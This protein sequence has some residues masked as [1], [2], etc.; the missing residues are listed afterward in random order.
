M[1]FKQYLA[2]SWEF[3]GEMP[4]FAKFLDEYMSEFGTKLKKKSEWGGLILRFYNVIKKTRDA[5]EFINNFN[6]VAEDF[7]VSV[8]LSSNPSDKDIAAAIKQVANG[9]M[10]EFAVSIIWEPCQKLIKSDKNL[11]SKMPKKSL[12][13]SW[14]FKSSMPEYAKFLDDYI[15]KFGTK[16]KKKSEWGDFIIRFFSAIK[17]D[18]SSVK[19]F[20]SNFNMVIED[21]EID[22][23]LELSSNPSDNDIAVVIKNIADSDMEEFAMCVTWEA[24]QN[25][26]KFD[27]A[28]IDKMPK[29]V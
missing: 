10:E 14:A 16:L 4:E 6:D 24:L 25:D 1:R 22:D 3:S 15:A 11:I 20:V 13:E 23:S 28:L 18:K 19:E 2:E 5:K 8:E 27:D 21:F 12:L 29:R 26:I 7:D 9:D 17:R